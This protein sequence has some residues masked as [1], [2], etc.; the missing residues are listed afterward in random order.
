MSESE[1]LQKLIE[2]L[3]QT[4]RQA[5]ASIDILNARI[6]ELSTDNETCLKLIERLEEEKLKY[7][8]LYD[9]IKQQNATKWKFAERDEWKALVD[10]I[11]QDRSRLQEENLSFANEIEVCK[12]QMNSL[13]AENEKLR[14]ELNGFRQDMNVS[15][16]SVDTV[17]DSA[18]LYTAE[19]PQS[20]QTRECSFD[21]KAA[22][23]SP[24]DQVAVLNT[25][26][27]R[28]R[29]KVSYK[30]LSETPLLLSLSFCK[31]AN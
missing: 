9:E 16:I 30:R 25:E 14:E 15:G 27:R 26:L 18:V 17:L 20:T 31:Y 24:R 7:K 12:E 4:R 5:E 19:S 8:T 11:Q 1:G 23:E 13:E 2:Y 10:S 6:N 22:S 28:A 29:A 21:S 3:K